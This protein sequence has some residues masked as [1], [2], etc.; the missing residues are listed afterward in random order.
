MGTKLAL[1][2]SFILFILLLIGT[3]CKKEDGYGGKATIKGKIIESIYD[4]DFTTLQNVKPSADEDVFIVF[5]NSVYG[6]DNVKTSASGDFEFKY[7][8]PGTYI[9]YIYS[10]DSANYIEGNKIAVKKEITISKS[11][12]TIDIGTFKKFKTLQY[13]EGTATI[14]GTLQTTYYV[15]NTN[16]IEEI[17]PSQNEDVFIIYN[18]HSYI[19]DR[20]RTSYDGS[21]A[22]TNLI[23]GKYKV[24]ALSDSLSGL[25]QKVPVYKEINITEDNQLVTLGTLNINNK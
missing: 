15:K 3:S 8:L 13:N 11:D 22:F 16:L 12:H 6:D 23:K 20:V 25:N 2:G 1:K 14:K 19:E 17:S 21:F 5:G 18:N 7:L 9:I 10:V 4:E 24:Y